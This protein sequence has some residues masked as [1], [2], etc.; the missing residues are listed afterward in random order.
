MK[1]IP[2]SI[3]DKFGR[4]TVVD[5]VREGRKWWIE[6]DCTC[7]SRIRTIKGSLTC[8]R[9]V[10]CGCF[11]RQATTERQ[12]TH[13]MCGRPEYIAFW[14]A[15][16]RCEN[17]RNPYF[18]NYGGRGIEM[19]FAS[20]EDFYNEVGPRPSARHS[21]DR[22]DNDGHYEQGNLRWATRRQQSDNQRHSNK[23]INARVHGL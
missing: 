1:W 22:V 9:T 8:G 11:S 2:I 3:G 13:E 20:F 16:M 5:M 12:K 15:K 10:S 23:H 4:L 17:P 18:K 7:G 19:R 21:I 14:N 6:C